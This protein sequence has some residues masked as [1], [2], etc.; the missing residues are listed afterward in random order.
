MLVPLVAWDFR[1]SGA[2]QRV[3][4]FLELPGERPDASTMLFR[5]PFNPKDGGMKALEVIQGRFLAHSFHYRD[6]RIKLSWALEFSP[7]DMEAF[8]RFHSSPKPG[9]P[10]MLPENVLC[11][12]RS[13]EQ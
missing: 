2:S 11:L 3:Y 12:L 4:G 9:G 8:R 6:G 7:E 10:F 5:E 1:N 13:V